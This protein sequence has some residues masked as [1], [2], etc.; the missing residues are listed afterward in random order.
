MGDWNS[1]TGDKSHRN[2]AGPHELGRTSQRGQMFTNV[3]ERD[4]LVITNIW[5]KKTVHLESPR[6][7][8]APVGLHTCK[9]S[10]LKQ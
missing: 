2:I 3:C 1:V 4:S 10:I 9:A 7:K 5:F 6:S 8:S